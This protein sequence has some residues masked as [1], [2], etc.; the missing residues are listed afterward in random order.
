MSGVLKPNLGDF[1][2][3]AEWQDIVTYYRGSDLQNYFTKILEEKVRRR[4][5]G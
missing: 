1:L 5:G 3:P 2:S 4:S